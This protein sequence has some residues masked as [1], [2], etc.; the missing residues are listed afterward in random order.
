[1]VENLNK[2]LQAEIANT[3]KETNFN[4]GKRVQGKVR[5][6]YIK[7]KELLIVSTDRIS[8]FD[9]CFST[10]PFKGQILNSLSQFWLKNVQDII[11]THLI[12][13]IDPNIMLTKRCEVIPVE[14]V[15]RGAIVGSGWRS[16]Q[17]DGTVSGIKLPSGLKRY[18]ML[19]QPILTPSTKA[20]SGQHD[21]PFS[22]EDII[23]SKIL[24]EK[25]FKMLEEV[26][27]ELYKRGYNHAAERG[28]I[29][30]DTK[31]EFG[32]LNDE[33]YLIDEVHTLDN[34]RYWDKESYE[35][36]FSEGKA[37]VMLDKQT[38][39]IWLNDR[40]FF[41]DGELPSIPDSWRVE[42]ANQYLESFKK[43]TGEDFK[44]VTGNHIERMKQSI[45]SL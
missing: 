41:G 6:C 30:A 9:V 19:E 38:A 25:T 8:C 42:F 32:F 43:L 23:S 35:E 20:E 12:E 29:L 33:I 39:R 14:F 10:I 3:I 45:A 24:S 18:Q 31:Y 21:Q 15:V 28:L 22:K 2:T 36:R 17:K 5:D 34:S 26:S 37:P 1:M 40:G 4:F 27:I 16:Y 11:P 13:V 7:D 44:P